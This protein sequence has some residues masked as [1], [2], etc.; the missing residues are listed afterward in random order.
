MDNN[1]NW[2]D[3][4]QTQVLQFYGKGKK[5]DDDDRARGIQRA[6]AS[7]FRVLSIHILQQRIVAYRAVY[8]V[9]FGLN[10]SLRINHGPPKYSSH[11]ARSLVLSFSWFTLIAYIVYTYALDIF[12]KSLGT[13][14]RYNFS[15]WENRIFHTTTINETAA[16]QQQ[17]GSQNIMYT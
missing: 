6:K 14:Y 5:N 15:M 16:H 12:E 10:S 13:M 1:T 8:S 9:C 4:L 3:D 17:R 7:L 2:C 11:R